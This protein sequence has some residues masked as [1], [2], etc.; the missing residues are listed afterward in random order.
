MPAIAHIFFFI[1]R[2]DPEFMQRDYA[3]TLTK[4]LLYLIFHNCFLSKSL[5][6]ITSLLTRDK[7]IG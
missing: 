3:L 5:V 1:T 2:V 7:F 4:W 6:R